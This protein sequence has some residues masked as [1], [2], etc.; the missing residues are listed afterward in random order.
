MRITTNPRDGKSLQMAANSFLFLVY[1]S[2][3]MA[4]LNFLIILGQ[5]PLTLTGGSLT[6]PIDSHD[7]SSFRL[8][9]STVSRIA[10]ALAI[11]ESSST[12]S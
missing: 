2:R 10:K 9:E 11:R 7:S 5:A 6:P 8:N 1:E 4:L 12:H 3:P